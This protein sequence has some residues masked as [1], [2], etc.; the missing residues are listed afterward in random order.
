MHNTYIK[1]AKD[2]PDKLKEV[3]NRLRSLQKVEKQK[4]AAVIIRGEALQAL[5]KQYDQYT[6]PFIIPAVSE[7]VSIRNLPADNSY[8][9]YGYFLY[10][11]RNPMP[12]DSDEWITMS[13]QMGYT[14]LHIIE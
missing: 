12:N 13:R 9:E 10:E 4:D 5:L 11:P 7:M 14:Q 2:A 3:I 6:A 8:T 1:N